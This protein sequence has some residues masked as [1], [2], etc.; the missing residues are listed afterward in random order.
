MLFEEPDDVL[1]GFVF[2]GDLEAF[3]TLVL[4]IKLLGFGVVIL[5]ELLRACGGDGVEVLVEL[6]E[7]QDGLVTFMFEIVKMVFGEAGLFVVFE[8]GVEIGLPVAD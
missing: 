3:E 2:K 1:M 8:V 4:T 7:G 5:L 6:V